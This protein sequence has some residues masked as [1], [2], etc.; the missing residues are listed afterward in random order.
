MMKWKIRV[1]LASV[2]SFL[3]IFLACQLAVALILCG[4]ELIPSLF[5]LAV[6]AEH[7]NP[8]HEYLEGLFVL[9]IG[10]EALKMLC[11]HTPGSALE[12]M[13]FTIAREM[14]VK[15]TSPLENLIVVI[16]IGVIFAIRKY[17]YV[18]AFGS[19]GDESP[20]ETSRRTLHHYRRVKKGESTQP[21]PPEMQPANASKITH[22]DED[23][24]ELDTAALSC[25]LTQ[26]VH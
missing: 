4:L 3:E 2:A 16:S 7:T 23:T 18:P 20:F 15:E 14:V 10:T 21:L 19:E 13:L 26:K 24:V 5:H 12:V 8:F 25:G 22:S 1:R 6:S 9:V 11:K 17:L